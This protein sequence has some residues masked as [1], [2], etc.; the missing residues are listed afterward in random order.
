MILIMLLMND[1]S[2]DIAASFLFVTRFFF[3]FLLLN[4]HERCTFAFAFAFAV[5][6]AIA[7][8]AAVA[9]AAASSLAAA[10]AFAPS[11]A[12]L[13]RSAIR[14]FSCTRRSRS[15]VVRLRSERIESEW[16]EETKQMMNTQYNKQQ[17]YNDISILYFASIF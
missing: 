7:F 12:V 15:D 1:H 2:Y 3:L 14:C 4:L 16:R 5:A 6:I 11:I 10:F 9:F 17:L 13:N 8:I